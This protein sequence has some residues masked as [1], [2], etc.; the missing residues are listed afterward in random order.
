LAAKGNG[1][2]Q[3]TVIQAIQS[4]ESQIDAHPPQATAGSDSSKL[5]DVEVARHI[6]FILAKGAPS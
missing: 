5:S 2:A 1:A 6:A 4:I 3:R